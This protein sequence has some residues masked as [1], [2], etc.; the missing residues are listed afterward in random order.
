MIHT[1]TALCTLATCGCHRGR[2]RGGEEGVYTD[3]SVA[4][5][6]DDWQE[7]EAED[8]SLI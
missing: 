5:K 7:Q 1:M 6:I 2:V 4:S 3:G 8:P